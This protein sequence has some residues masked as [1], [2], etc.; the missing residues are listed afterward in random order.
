MARLNS[1]CS[2]RCMRE[3]DPRRRAAILSFPQQMGPARIAAAV[4]RRRVHRPPVRR[5][6]LLRGVYFTSGTQ[7][8][9]PI[10]RMLGA[11]ARSFGL[12]ASRLHVPGA[13]SRTFFVER[14]LQ[15]RAVP[16]VGFRRH[17]PEARAPEGPAA[18]GLL[19]RRAAGAVRLLV[20]AW[21][22]VIGA[23]APISPM[24]MRRCRSIRARAISR[25]RPT[26][27]RISRL[28]WQRLEGLSA[29]VGCCATA[30]GRRAADDALRP[31]SGQCGR[32]RGAR[33]LLSRAQRHPA[34]GRGLAVPRGPRCQCRRSAGVVLLPQGLPDAWRAQASEPRRDRGTGRY[35][36]AQAV[37]QRPCAAEGAGQALRRAG[38]H[39]G[40][41]ASA[42][43][44]TT[45]W[46]SRRAVPCAPPT[47]RR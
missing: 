1:A 9:T 41:V 31:V 22:P 32:R 3:R 26:S 12:D 17:R 25:W 16:R 37:P 5:P 18:G 34:A 43:A 15:G 45:L 27:R 8:G 4:R 7:E 14:L 30:Q 23:T 47:C 33:C 28:C 20:W 39:E 11:V 13:Q 36:M 38:R 19:C 46:W 21:P 24:C 35:R 10:D 29:V 6:V 40:A 2:T 42:A 44:W